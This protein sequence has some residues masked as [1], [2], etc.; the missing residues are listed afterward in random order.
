MLAAVSRV[1]IYIYIFFFVMNGYPSN[2]V[3]K[4]IRDTT[5][6]R[7]VTGGGADLA[8][9]QQRASVFI[10]LPWMGSVSNKFKKDISAAI[11][12]GFV[13]AKPLV[14]FSTTTA[15]SGRVK[16]P[17]PTTS[18][19]NLVYCYRCSC[20]RTY[21]GKTV[22]NL[23]ERI[24]QHIPPKLLLPGADLRRKS[25]DSAITRHLKENSACLDKLRK[26]AAAE[27]F[28][29][30]CQARSRSALDVLEALFLFTSWHLNCEPERA[31]S[32]FY[33]LLVIVLL[34]WV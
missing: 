4:V 10:R 7:E 24:K 21:V 22:Q 1:V 29:V 34:S 33:V 25:A 3:D 6:Q 15:F 19:N 27:R 18:K 23:S 8:E 26:D 28:S 14:V 17:L 13:L 11:T 16:D 32:C 2:L 30:L 12:D 5:V 31:C 9:E 20:A